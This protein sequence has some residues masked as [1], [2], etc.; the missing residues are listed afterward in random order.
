MIVVTAGRTA[1]RDPGM[2]AVLRAIDSHVRH[3]DDI[4]ILRIDRHL[5][6]VPATPPERGVRRET[7]PRVAAVVGPE[8]STLHR[9]RRHATA[10]TRG[11]HVRRCRC[12]LRTGL[13]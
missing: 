11:R 4:S 12:R 5:L 13:R 1:K 7:R 2:S 9:W 10:T 6:E 3:V 8:K